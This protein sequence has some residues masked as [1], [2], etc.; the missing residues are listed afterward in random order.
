MGGFKAIVIVARANSDEMR[1]RDNIRQ[2]KAIAFAFETYGPALV[3]MRTSKVDTVLVEFDVETETIDFCDA[4][5][6]LKIPILFSANELNT[7]TLAEYG[8][9]RSDIIYPGAPSKEER[10]DE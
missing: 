7:R 3:L 2:R 8:L 6:A 5:K 1:L 4:A 9:S 10:V